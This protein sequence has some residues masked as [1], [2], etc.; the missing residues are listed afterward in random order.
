[1]CIYAKVNYII[2]AENEFG[3]DGLKKGWCILNLTD[4]KNGFMHPKDECH[5][6]KFHKV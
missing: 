1:M 6:S 3:K 2:T 5:W 4:I